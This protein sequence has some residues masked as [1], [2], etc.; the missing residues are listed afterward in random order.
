MLMKKIVYYL[1]CILSI[2]PYSQA[3][4]HIGQ[5][6]P[7]FELIDDH[8][9]TRSL[10]SCKGKKVALVFYPADGSRYCTKQAKAIKDN[11]E[12]LLKEGI[13]VFGLSQDPISKHQSFKEEYALPFDLLTV[14]SDVL[15]AYN[16]DGWF[17]NKRI[18]FLIDEEGYVMSIISN[19]DMQKHAQQILDGF[20]LAK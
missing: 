19:V 17:I 4:L 13:V 16:A 12:Q 14:T 8:G 18:T 15:K 11:F 6:A 20:K 9:N 10:I 1:T 5:K 3:K 7:N 2:F